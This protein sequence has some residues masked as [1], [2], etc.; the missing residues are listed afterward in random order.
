MS[1]A[2][3]NPFLVAGV[4]ICALMAIVSSLRYK[5][6]GPSAYI[7]AFAFAVLGAAMLLVYVRAPLPFIVLSGVILII[8][9]GADFAAR[10]SHPAKKGK[11]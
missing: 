5:T 11:P 4:I 7:M 8:L 6:R 1:D 10:S 2:S 3:L 9:L